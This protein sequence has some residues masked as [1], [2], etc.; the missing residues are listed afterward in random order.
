MITRTQPPASALPPPAAMRRRD[1]L[2]RLSGGT[3]AVGLPFLAACGGGNDDSGASGGTPQ[4]EPAPGADGSGRT[5]TL[6]AV[7]AEFSAL[8][9]GPAT[10]LEQVQRLARFMSDRSDYVEVGVDEATL[11]AWGSFADGRMHI[12]A[13][14]LQPARRQAAAPLER[15]LT[16]TAAAAGKVEPPG[17]STAR[18]MQSFGPDFDGADVV[19]DLAGWLVATGYQLQP[20]NRTTAELT[21][22]RQV[23]G[24]GFFYLNAHGGAGGALLSPNSQQTVYSMQ[25]STLV[26]DESERD[27]VIRED[28]AQ[29]RLTYFTATN[30]DGEEDTR[31]G[32]TAAFVRRYWRFAD[33]SVLLMNVCSGARTDNARWASDFIAACHDGNAAV[34]L[35]WTDVTTPQGAYPAARYFSDRLLGT[36]R[37]RAEVPPQRPFPWNEVLADMHTKGVD[38]DPNT[39]AVLVAKPRPAG[40]GTVQILAPSIHHVEVDEYRGELRLIGRF[41]QRQGEVTIDDTQRAIVSWSPELVVCELPLQ[42]KGSCGAVQV[43]VRDLRSNLRQLSLWTLALDF[44][45]SMIPTA[46][47]KITGNGTIRLRADLGATRELP[48]GP[49]Q[50]PVRYAYA[51]R[52]SSLPL[53]ASGALASCPWIGSATYPGI[54]MEGDHHEL[55]AYLK[56]DTASH[57]GSLGLAL[58]SLGRDFTQTCSYASTPVA[59]TFGVL[60]LLQNYP[61][62]V[63]GSSDQIPLHSLSLAFGNEFQIPEDSRTTPVVKLYWLQAK[64]RFPPLATDAV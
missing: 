29:R 39:H 36:N 40:A 43:R 24:D 8:R 10:A 13:N 55:A 33:N 37:F 20:G 5:R 7:E 46:S 61:S 56:V 57:T 44:R 25:S 54:K 3:L 11:C 22:L 53:M 18:L 23:Q 41:G 47:A 27:P 31:Y 9:A 32:I 4:G 58:G 34:Y 52:D 35:G 49:V 1:F 17:E 63:V 15:A 12:V 19:S 42:G 62:P 38:V 45:F 30:I 51:T 26:S 21:A 6:H 14:N 28:L 16:A 59:A 50:Q 2:A 48:G 64:P 60:D